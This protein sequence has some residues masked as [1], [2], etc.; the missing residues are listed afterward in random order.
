MRL[1]L[2]I[3]LPAGIVFGIAG[4]V[5]M[6]LKPDPGIWTHAPATGLAELGRSLSS[7]GEL[8]ELPGVWSVFEPFFWPLLVLA[9]AGL[10]FL[11]RRRMPRLLP[12]DW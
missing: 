9:S 6:G 2:L 5:M 7:R 3:A 11:A 4:A 1:I 10:T 8:I 12:L